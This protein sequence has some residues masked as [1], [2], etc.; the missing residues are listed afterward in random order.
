MIDLSDR[1]VLPVKRDILFQ[2]F[3]ILPFSAVDFSRRPQ[4]RLM[5]L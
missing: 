5:L 3:G 2:T 1:T 4:L